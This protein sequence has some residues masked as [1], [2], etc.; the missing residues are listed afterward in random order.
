MAYVKCVT[1]VLLQH[2]RQG[3]LVYHG[4]VGHLLLAGIGHVLRVRVIADMEMRVRSAMQQ[5]GMGRDEAIAHIERVDRDRARWARLLYGV[6]WDDPHQYHLVLNLG[7][8]SVGGACDAI[9]RV[10][11]LPELRPTAESRK[12]L[13]DLSLSCRVWAALA[14]DRQA[15]SAGVQVVADDGRV[16]I[17]GSVGSSAAA[18]AIQRIAGGVDGVKSLQCEVGVGTDWYW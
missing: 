2:A 17:T 6:E 1:A 13:E 14:R 10:A 16:T 9:A 8:I 5:A 7:G 4:H 3:N 18:E 12:R 15:R 11:E